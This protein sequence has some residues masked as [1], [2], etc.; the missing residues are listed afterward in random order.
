MNLTTTS[1]VVRMTS[2]E[3]LELVNTARA[4]SGESAVRHADF[5]SRCRDELDGE[6]YENF[7]VQNLNSTTTEALRMTADQCKLVAMRESKGV[8][9][10]VL[11]RLNEL[12]AGNA[13]CIPRTMAEALRLA[14]DQAEQ[15]EQQQAALAIAAPKV[16][17]VD[18]FVVADG[19]YGFRQVAK[20]LRAKENEFSQWL[21]E[22]GIMYRL[23]GKLTPC[24][25]HLDTGRFEVKAGA[26]DAGHAFTQAKFTA[27]GFEWVAGKW[28]VRQMMAGN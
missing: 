12:E 3:L 5:A 10:A 6:Y 2:I 19:L 28:A 13:H 21:V 18:R 25:A 27:K 23:A 20:M 4:Q 24:A 22:S 16:E 17:F 26:S 9:R 1:N 7:V 11:A 14:A 15:I 8:R